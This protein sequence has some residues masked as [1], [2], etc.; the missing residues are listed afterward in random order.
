VT[1][2]E[3]RS[4]KPSPDRAEHSNDD[5]QVFPLSATARTGGEP[6]N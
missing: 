1:V 2:P 5:P 6:T 3:G 4:A